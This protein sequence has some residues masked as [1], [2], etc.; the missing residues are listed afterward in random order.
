MKLAVWF[1]FTGVALAIPQNFNWSFAPVDQFADLLN[2]NGNRRRF[3]DDS[4]QQRASYNRNPPPLYQSW[5][6]Q[7]DVI[8]SPKVTS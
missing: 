7:D 3:Y 6:S 5:H 1:L 4:V 2:R 8:P